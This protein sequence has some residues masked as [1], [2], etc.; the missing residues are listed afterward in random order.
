MGLFSFLKNAGS[1]IFNSA[2][3]TTPSPNLSEA[4]ARRAEE[5]ARKQKIIVLKGVVNS[6]NLP[7]ED[8]DI[9][10]HKDTVTVYG[11]AQTQADKEKIILALGNV[12]G[13]AAVD[14][15]MIVDNPEPEAVFYEVKRGDSL[16]KIAKAHYGN[17][18]KYPVI[19]EANKPML[20]DPDKIYPGQVLR[21]PS[22]D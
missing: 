9:N 19:F 6:L 17:A 12:A 14:D 2:T 4:E 21:I 8:L 16:S 10:Y 5:I 11:K 13:V 15:R 7:V 22:L 20:K 18:M 1:K 3:K